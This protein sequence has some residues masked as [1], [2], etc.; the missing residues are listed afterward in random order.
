MSAF[1]LWRIGLFLPDRA[2]L[3]ICPLFPL[4]VCTFCSPHPP[5]PPSTRRANQLPGWGTLSAWLQADP[6]RYLKP[7]GISIRSRQSIVYARKGLACGCQSTQQKRCNDPECN[8]SGVTSFGVL[9]RHRRY[10]RDQCWLSCARD[11][12]RWSS[13]RKHCCVSRCATKRFA[14]ASIIV[15]KKCWF[16]EF[17]SEERKQKKTKK[18]P[19]IK[20]F[21]N[22]SYDAV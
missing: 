22:H 6:R 3:S 2:S 7:T 5:L 17:N 20:D 13:A 19:R 10:P 9:P 8:R 4:S 14:R 21:Y 16:T 12:S 18:I 1:F 11:S 15:R